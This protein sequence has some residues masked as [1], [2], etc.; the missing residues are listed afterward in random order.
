MPVTYCPE[1]D[2]DLKF[3]SSPRKG[4][5]ITCPSCG[6]HLEVVGLS[7]IELDWVYDDD[8]QDLEEWDFEDN[9]LQEEYDN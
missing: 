4:D 8:D 3:Q 5:T 2:G 9:E 6:A 1:C 7:P